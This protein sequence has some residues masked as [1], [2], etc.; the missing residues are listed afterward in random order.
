M[1]TTGKSTAAFTSRS[2]SGLG[3]TFEN[4]FGEQRWVIESSEHLMVPTHKIE[5]GSAF[6][7]NLDHFKCYRVVDIVGA[8]LEPIL[9]LRDQFGAQQDIPLGKPL[10][11]CVPVAKVGGQ[12]KSS[13]TNPDDHL[14]VYAIRNEPTPREQRVENQFGQTTLK[15]RHSIMLCVP[16]IKNGWNDL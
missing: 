3:V 6:P 7:K 12:H 10:Y 14:A 9:A 2:S 4:Q 1:A 16:S 11:F 15:V 13:I 5:Q 8:P